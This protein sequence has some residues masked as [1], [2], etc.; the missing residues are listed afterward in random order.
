MRK[1]IETPRTKCHKANFTAASLK[2]GYQGTTLS[3]LL[4]AGQR[5]SFVQKRNCDDDSDIQFPLF[6]A[7]LHA[8]QNFVPGFI[9]I[10]FLWFRMEDRTCEKNFLRVGQSSGN[11]RE[12]CSVVYGSSTYLMKHTLICR[13]FTKTAYILRMLIFTKKSVSFFI[14]QK[15]WRVEALHQTVYTLYDLLQ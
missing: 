1:I 6:A 2:K 3:N 10:Y 12:F 4:P 5:G 13:L 15:L 7:G 9:K 11:A 14:I 8:P